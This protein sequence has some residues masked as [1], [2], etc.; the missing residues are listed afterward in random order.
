[1]QG[2]SHH[3]PIN[4]PSLDIEIAWA[5]ILAAEV[6]TLQLRPVEATLRIVLLVLLVLVSYENLCF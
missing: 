3:G 1:M 4:L 6:S 5:P 2:S